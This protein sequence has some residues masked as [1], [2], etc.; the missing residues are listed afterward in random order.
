MI[1]R[2]TII[3][4]LL[5][6]YLTIA[7]SAES[8]LYLEQ[9]KAI[10]GSFEYRLPKIELNSQKWAGNFFGNKCF[11][12]SEFEGG[13]VYTAPRASMFQLNHHSVEG[14]WHLGL[15]VGAIWATYSLGGRYYLAGND[16]GI[17]EG[18]ELANTLRVGIGWK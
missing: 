5:V 13:L 9:T 18:S 8:F 2:L 17:A 7:A 12:L 3:C 6:N 10:N 4:L 1:K 14:A 16:S 11:Y 15:E